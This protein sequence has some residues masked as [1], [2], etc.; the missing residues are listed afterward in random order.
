MKVLYTLNDGQLTGGNQIA[1][2]LLEARLR[3]GRPAAAA[4]PDDGPITERMRELRV[5][6][7]RADLRRSFHFVEAFRLAGRIRRD[8]IDLVHAHGPAPHL[9]LAALAGRIAKKPV[10]AHFHLTDNFNRSPWIRMCQTR[11][12]K[13]ALAQKHV[14]CVAVSQSICRSNPLLNGSA[15]PAAVVPNGV[16]EGPE[17]S[18]SRAWL[19]AMTNIPEHAPVLVHVGRLCKS[20][21]Q[22]LSIEAMPAVLERHPEARLILIGEDLAAGGSYLAQ[23]DR[24]IRSLGLQHRILLPGRR[25]DATRWIAGS[26]CLLL[27]SRAEGLPLVVI[28]AMMSGIPAIASRI[29]GIPELI[30]DGREGLLIPAEDARAL[31]AAVLRLLQDPSKKEEMGREAQR[32]ARGSFGVERMAEKIFTVYDQ[33]LSRSNTA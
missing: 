33:A 19:R 29:D 13:T 12:F 6:V 31:G 17:K 27:P 16:P 21:G 28:E 5:P 8:G 3:E 23:L 4:I 1:L 18:S 22:H 14:T 10:I 30:D 2:W 7:Y 25:A 11:F 20:K 15:R 24:K 9:A 32:K 26:D